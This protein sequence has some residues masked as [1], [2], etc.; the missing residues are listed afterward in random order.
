MGEPAD[1]VVIGGGHAGCEASA[2]S[3]R[4][5]AK[6]ALVT[7]KIDGIGTCSCNPSFGGIGKGTLVREVDALDGLAARIID[8]AGVH[9]RVLNRSQ[10]PAVRG[11]RAQ[12][13]RSLYKKHMQNE[14]MNYKN[15]TVLEDSVKDI[16][17]D[18]SHTG[19]AVCSGTVCGVVLESGKI[20]PTSQ[21]VITTGT[22]LSGEI[23][24]GQ[25]VYP[26]GRIGEPATFGISDTLKQAGFRLGRLKTGTPPRLDKNT[27]DFSNLEKQPGDMPPTAMSFM[28]D[29]PDVKSQLTCYKTFTTTKSHQIIRENMH[30]S[31]HIRETVNGPRYCPS[32]ESKIIRFPDKQSHILWLEPEGF[33]SNVIYPNGISTTLPEENQLELLRSIPG[34]ENVTMLQPGYGVEYDYIDPRDL[35]YSLESKLVNGLFFAG[36]INGTTGYEEAAAQGIIAGANAGLAALGK[37][38]LILTRRD[39]Y[40]GILIDDLITKGVTEPYRMFTSRSEYR[41][42]VRADNASYRL[43]ERARDCG[44]V[45]DERWTYFS[46]KKQ[47]LS[48][49]RQLLLNMSMSPNK[50]EAEYGIKMNND[51]KIR[52][53]ME[54]MRF[55][56]ANGTNIHKELAEK[57]PELAKYSDDIMEQIYIEAKYSVYLD[58]EAKMAENFSAQENL[59]LPIDFDYSSLGT[60]MCNEA[61]DA[62]NTLRPETLGQARRLQGVNPSA[63]MILYQ[64]VKNGGMSKTKKYNGFDLQRKTDTS[65]TL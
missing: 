46:N 48:E 56:D 39:A 11:P 45:R 27:I 2:A 41:L 36:Q 23:H 42:S 12:I 7:P 18:D 47:Q 43:T 20:V 64:L 15:L 52:N 24:I 53:G 22:F 14:I 63:W 1:V 13:D 33:D 60:A 59:Q 9:F 17:I 3:A 29:K 6:T 51:G 30:K 44:I 16:I 55:E 37:D 19:S 50:W 32:I 54:I 62:L 34:L 5:G 49:A 57:I 4:S 25:T 10:G 28:N 40:I 61:K 8:K 21:V 31:I 65:A 58:R 38:P 35:R 26:A